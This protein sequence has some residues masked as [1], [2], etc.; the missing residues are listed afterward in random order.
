MPAGC[1]PSIGLTFRTSAISPRWTGVRL[2][3]PTSSAADSP[4][5]LGV[6]Q[7]GDSARKTSAGS[8]LSSQD[9]FATFDPITCSWRTSQ[10]SLW[11]DWAT[12]SEAWPSWGSMRTGRVYRQP[13]LVRPIFGG[14]SSFWLTPVARDYKGYTKREGESICNQLRRI[15]GGSGAPNPTWLEWLMGFPIGW[16]DVSPE[17]KPSA[18]PSYPKSPNTS[19]A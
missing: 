8:G 6:S 13:P 2:S 18:T 11:E 10:G 15:H 1:S 16:T 4:A 14:E 17:P 19:A 7:E 3:D 5:S 12:Y 9:A